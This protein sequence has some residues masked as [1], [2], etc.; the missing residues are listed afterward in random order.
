MIDNKQKLDVP[1]IE[2]KLM[3]IKLMEELKRICEKHSMHY[4]FGYGSVLGAIR[5]EGFIPWDTDID[6]YVSID[7]YDDFCSILNQE[8]SNEYSVFS[9]NNNEEYSQLFARFGYKIY[10]D[11]DIHIDIFP[12][13]GA[14]T[15]KLAKKVLSLLN[16]VNYRLFHVKLYSKNVVFKDNGKKYFLSKLINI[17]TFFIEAKMQKRIYKYFAFLFPIKES[18]E[19]YNLCSSYGMREFIPKKWYFDTTKKKFES[20]EVLVPLEWDEYLKHFY[21]DY[22]TPRKTNYLSK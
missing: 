9:Y 3:E 18:K 2:I 22:M 21:G 16:Y 4:C 11:S 6:I 8:A 17:L 12:L 20:L 19:L 13:V 10:G 14:P 5:H 15:N 7:E 1:L